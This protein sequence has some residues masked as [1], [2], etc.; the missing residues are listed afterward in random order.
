MFI[1]QYLPHNV[2][3]SSVLKV[4]IVTIKVTIVSVIMVLYVIDVQ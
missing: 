3:I 1:I 4:V 2:Q